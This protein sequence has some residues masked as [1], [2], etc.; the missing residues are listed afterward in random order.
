MNVILKL[1]SK[2]LKE[3]PYFSNKAIGPI[4]KERQLLKGQFL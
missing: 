4:N 3:D 2:D 1:I